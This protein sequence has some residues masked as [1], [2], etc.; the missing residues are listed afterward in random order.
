V[1]QSVLDQR[2]EELLELVWELAEE[3]IHDTE[4]VCESAP[5]RAQEEQ[6][7]EILNELVSRSLVRLDGSYLRLTRQGEEAA[8]S[9]VRRHRLAERLLHDVLAVDD[10]T[11][12][13]AACRFEHV[14]SAEVTDSICT[15]L[16]HPP[17]CPHGQPI[18]PGPC[19]G[20]FKTEVQPIV[21]RLRELGIGQ[22]GT[23]SL[24]GTQRRGRLE[25]L[26]ALGLVPGVRLRL[27]Q[28]RPA[29][30]IQVGETEVAIDDDVASEI[31]VRSG[32]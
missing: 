8:R 16:G 10:S 18:P 32:G 24:L 20:I 11:M 2:V 13:N 3:G 9:I 26:G 22:S 21:H 23:I 12:A 14:L 19:C 1:H 28:K 6:P 5:Q 4:R 31:Y 25:R 27:I 29:Y 30:V 15:L 17:T 7:R